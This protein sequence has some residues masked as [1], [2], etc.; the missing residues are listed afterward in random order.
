MTVV[1]PLFTLILYSLMILSR[2][3][4][5]NF[6]YLHLSYHSSLNFARAVRKI[7]L[8]TNDLEVLK[9]LLS[10]TFKIL[11]PPSKCFVNILKAFELAK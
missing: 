9:Y 11:E 7:S 1:S 6:V 5:D 2:S 4:K 10:R 3:E 8:A